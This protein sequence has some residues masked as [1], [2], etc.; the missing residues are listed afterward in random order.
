MS[1]LDEET[2]T[3]AY[4]C[5]TVQVH[6]DTNEE[7]QLGD[8]LFLRRRCAVSVLVPAHLGTHCSPPTSAR[9]PPTAHTETKLTVSLCRIYLGPLRS[10]ALSRTKRLVA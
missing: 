8:G 10:C 9:R 1:A 3:K 4:L 2:K 5:E 7:A 6:Y